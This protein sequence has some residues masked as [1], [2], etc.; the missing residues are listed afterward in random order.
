MSALLAVDS[1][2]LPASSR[3][4]WRSSSALGPLAMKS[5]TSECTSSR[6]ASLSSARVCTLIMN[7]PATCIGLKAE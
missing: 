1:G 4:A 2:K 5:R 3:W 6:V 7:G